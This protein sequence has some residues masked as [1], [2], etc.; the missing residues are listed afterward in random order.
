MIGKRTMM[1]NMRVIDIRRRRGQN[2]LR[3]FLIPLI[4]TS[5]FIL[6]NL[7]YLIYLPQKFSMNSPEYGLYISGFS[8]SFGRIR[9][10]GVA[11]LGRYSPGL[12]FIYSCGIKKALSLLRD[13]QVALYIKFGSTYNR[14]DYALP[15][16]VH[17]SALLRW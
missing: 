3:H 1:P 6:F 14:S 13:S 9:A 5:L 11:P 4:L 15:L 16:I 8:T 2:I 7:Y 17:R 12:K 10:P